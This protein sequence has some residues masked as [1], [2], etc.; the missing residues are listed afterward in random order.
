ME[1]FNLD[2]IKTKRL[3]HG[4]GVGFGCVGIKRV[5]PSMNQKYQW[6]CPLSLIALILSG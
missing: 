1:G 3:Y 5:N 2:H 6:D 4:I